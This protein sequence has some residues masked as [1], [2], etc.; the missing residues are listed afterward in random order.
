MDNCDQ[1]DN[2]TIHSLDDC[3]YCEKAK[4][5]L[6]SISKTY[7]IVKYNKNDED[8][9]RKL[10]ELTKVTNYSRFPQIFVNG[11]FIG[12]YQNLVKLYEF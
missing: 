11:E 7:S 3:Y 10:D 5:F 8:Y 1:L 9:S 2:I 6:D 4:D 12:G